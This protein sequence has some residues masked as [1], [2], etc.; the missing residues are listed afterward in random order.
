M[1]IKY[2]LSLILSWPIATLYAA[3]TN[4]L[5]LDQKIDKAFQPFSD[6]VSSVVFFEVFEGP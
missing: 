2:L 4:E 5:G 1:N 6:F 3:E